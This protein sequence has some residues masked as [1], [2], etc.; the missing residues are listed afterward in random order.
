[1]YHLN[2]DKV[3]R[4]EARSVNKPIQITELKF[5]NLLSRHLLRYF[6]GSPI[7]APF[8]GVNTKKRRPKRRLP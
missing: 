7:L 3:V 1:V 6:P 4:G 2:R 8:A 5:E